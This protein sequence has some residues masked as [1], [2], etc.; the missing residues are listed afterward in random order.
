MCTIWHQFLC[1]FYVSFKQNKRIIYGN[2]NKQTF[3]CFPKKGNKSKQWML[4]HAYLLPPRQHNKRIHLQDKDSANECI[5]MISTKHNI[6]MNSFND[7]NITQIIRNY[8]L[9]TFGT[10]DATKYFIAILL[11][12]SDCVPC[13][14]N[15][16]KV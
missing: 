10:R 3:S 8:I 16:H 5:H 4:R 9:T 7:N 12:L 1:V 6:R 2:I 14:W 11:I 13:L 15:L